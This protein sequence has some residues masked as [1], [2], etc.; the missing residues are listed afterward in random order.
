MLGF[1]FIAA[2]GG[3]VVGSVAVLVWGGPSRR[4]RAILTVVWIEGLLLLVGMARPHPVL[5]GAAG[6]GVLC[7][8]P[9]LSS[10]AETLWQRTVPSSIQGR[11]FSTRNAVCS[12]AFPVAHLL[13]GPLADLGELLMAHEGPL[14]STVG[15]LLGTGPGRGASLIFCLQAGCLMAAAL[16]AAR[17]VSLRGLEGRT[18]Q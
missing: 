14:A 4:V 3:M 10:A 13:G 7:C 8:F 12:A 11:V 17:S 1:V 5:I 15:A 18:G 6:F 2:G 9:V 16:L